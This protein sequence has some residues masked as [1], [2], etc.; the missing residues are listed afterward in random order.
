[1]QIFPYESHTIVSPLSSRD[2]ITKL[3]EVKQPND[4]PKQYEMTAEL[5]FLKKEVPKDY[6]FDGW[7]KDYSFNIYR[8]THFPEHYNPIIKGKI[9]ETS[10]NTILY[11]RYEL[12]PSTL[13]FT[14]LSLFIYYIIAF[15]FI[16]LKQDIFIFTMTSSFFLI[17]YWVLLLN[18]KQKVKIS[19]DLLE[20]VLNT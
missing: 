1:M 7:I 5:S 6:L 18:F 11:L 9:E 13:F 4:E 17:C 15:T 10:L 3:N 14:R 20:Q 12:Q 16:A 8:I 2:I 19:K